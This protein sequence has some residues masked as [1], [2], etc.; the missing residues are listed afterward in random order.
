MLFIGV[1]HDWTPLPTEV[2]C[3]AVSSDQWIKILLALTRTTAP[4]NTANLEMNSPF[5]PSLEEASSEALLCRC[6]RPIQARISYTSYYRLYMLRGFA[7]LNFLAV[8]CASQ[9]KYHSACRSAGFVSLTSGK[10][11]SSIAEPIKRSSGGTK[12]ATNR[13]LL[14]NSHYKNH[15]R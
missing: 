6:R 10:V 3:T 12:S 14:R 7:Q 11:Q 4:L 9:I 15:H 2:Q 1:I 8:A 5:S 13:L